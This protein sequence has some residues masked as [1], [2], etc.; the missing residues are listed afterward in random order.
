MRS[1]SILML[2]SILTVTVQ[3]AKAQTSPLCA[4]FNGQRPSD[5]IYR[6][7]FDMVAGSKANKCAQE[8]AVKLARSLDSADLVAE[9][10]VGACS[11]EAAKE[12]KSLPPTGQSK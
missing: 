6:R 4:M 5:P 10:A 1:V 12:A 3:S 11:D 7:N 9:A 2:C 8:M